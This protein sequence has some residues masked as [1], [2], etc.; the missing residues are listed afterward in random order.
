MV[1]PWKGYWWRDQKCARQQRLCR[2]LL[3]APLVPAAEEECPKCDWLLWA[4]L[5]S[6]LLKV[7]LWLTCSLLIIK[8]E[9]V[10]AVQFIGGGILEG[11]GVL[12][13]TKGDICCQGT[14]LGAQGLSGNGGEGPEVCR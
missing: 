3:L 2:S 13:N 14:P 1:I 9:E 4:P 5:T 7:C 11:G 8:L 12:G 10:M 6:G